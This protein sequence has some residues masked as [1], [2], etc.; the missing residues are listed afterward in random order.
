MKLILGTVQLGLPYGIQGNGQP[1]TNEA[2]KILNSAYSAGITTFDTASGY[3]KAETILNR[4]LRQKNIREENIAIIT[5]TAAQMNDLESSITFSLSRMGIKRLEGVLLH[6]PNDL[7]ISE[8]VEALKKI[9]DKGLTQKIGASVYTPEQAMKALEY[10]MIDLIQVPYN[11]FDRRLDHCGFFEMAREKGVEIHARSVLLQGLLM[12]K[13]EL[14]PKNMEF[15]KQYLQLFRTICR[16]YDLEPFRAAVE[17]VS[18]HDLIDGI[19]FGVDN[20]M[21]LE[22]YLSLDFNSKEID[23]RAVF[24]NSFVQVEERLIMPTLW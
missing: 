2:L 16:D 5:K 24:D 1:D 12:I 11:I 14:L 9:K 13:P 19:V 7:F 10:H 18:K 20:A 23:I 6:D 17:F 15:T 3:G 8:T 4:F 22:A 21:Q